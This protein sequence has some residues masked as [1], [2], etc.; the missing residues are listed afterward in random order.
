MTLNS[1]Q[2][3][4]EEIEANSFIKNQYKK[5]KKIESM[6]LPNDLTESESQNDQNCKN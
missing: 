1:S 5:P 6:Q 2:D 3:N 4:D